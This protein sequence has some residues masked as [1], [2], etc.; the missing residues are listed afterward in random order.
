MFCISIGV[1]VVQVYAFV[2]THCMVH[3]NFVHFIVCK[4]YLEISKISIL[5]APLE[6][7]RKVGRSM[8]LLKTQAPSFLLLAGNSMLA[9]CLHAGCLRTQ[10][11]SLT[12]HWMAQWSSL[13]AT[14]SYCLWIL[15]FVPIGFVILAF[16]KLL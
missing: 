13:W 11:G 5:T 6:R 10:H 2:N 7:C 1:W 16:F 14:E 8:L 3:L 9:F 4:F 15:V 12:L